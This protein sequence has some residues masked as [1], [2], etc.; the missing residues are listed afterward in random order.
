MPSDKSLPSTHKA[1]S[2][3][4]QQN[5][6]IS[7]SKYH[8]HLRSSSAN[9][10]TKFAVALNKFTRLVFQFL[11]VYLLLDILVLKQSEGIFPLGVR[12]ESVHSFN[13]E[14][15][16]DSEG[17]AEGTLKEPLREFLRNSNQIEGGGF[18]GHTNGSAQN[19]ENSENT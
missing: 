14:I 19:S 4:Q 10:Q 13:T 8:G 9:N 5:L 1:R 7:N 15:L 12:E 2:R 16:K 17:T 6:T 11:I 18:H 3:R